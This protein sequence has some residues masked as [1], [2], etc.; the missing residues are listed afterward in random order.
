MDTNKQQRL[1]GHYQPA[2]AEIASFAALASELTALVEQLQLD[3][4]AHRPIENIA[5]H[6]HGLR[7]RAQRLFEG[8]D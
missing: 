2:V 7:E 8:C 5:A 4:D 3:R 6:V 1:S